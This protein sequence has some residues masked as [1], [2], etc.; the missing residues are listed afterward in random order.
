MTEAAR[1][2]PPT[3]FESPRAMWALIVAYAV[4]VFALRW[5]LFPA[6]SQDDAEQIVFA[7]TLA[8]G[9]NPGQPPLVTWLIHFVERAF[10]APL[11]AVLAVKYAFILA[12]YVFLYL[13]A[14]SVLH[15]RLLAGLAALSP[16]ALLY[17]GWDALVNYSNTIA[18]AV[19]CAA[20]FF[21]F[22]RVV[23]SGS[24][25]AYVGLG[26]AAA[27]GVLAKYGYG[28]FI[29]ALLLAAMFEPAMRKR[30][31]NV[32]VLIA[33]AVCLLI[34]AP[35]IIWLI[36]GGD[37]ISRAFAE[38]LSAEKA[39]GYLSGAARGLVKLAN[40]VVTFL[41]P[42]VLIMPALF[43]PALLPRKRQ[44]DV[45]PAPAA[46]R[47]DRF[48]LLMFAAMIAI[49]AAGV[50]LLGVSNV[51]THY[52]FILLL[53]PLFVFLRIEAV[54]VAAWRL[55]VY[56][57]V[58][59]GAC[60]VSTG[61]LV[62]RH[63]WEPLWER[64]PY[65]HM[66]YAALAQQLRAAGFSYG[67]IVADYD[68]KDESRIYRIYIDG[69]LRAQFPSSR[70]VSVKYPWYQPPP[71]AIPNDGKAFPC[72]LIWDTRNGAA[73]SARLAE[74]AAR[75]CTL[76]A[77]LAGQVRYVE[78]PLLNAPKQTMKLGYVIVSAPH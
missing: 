24:V 52:M 22:A 75:H 6:A 64:K 61:G 19:A 51:R 55:R 63:L 1:K 58:L 57:W 69:N 3:L 74:F 49:L 54:G 12:I 77:S 38:R 5:T 43:W 32:R 47:W 26:V 68:V 67:T 76:P 65:L 72:I 16:V 45:A 18:L 70:V 9:Y 42:L 46:P 62:V 13:A 39:P 36:E 56:G 2:F 17:V 60:L 35:H 4:V 66:P 20:S 23:R 53:A 44:P 10:G 41:F 7:Q 31:L 27:F 28:V 30:M 40:A 14:R 73:L 71:L 59:I 29:G 25:W 33:V 15:D 48:L 50:L 8:A 34:L 78:A 11:F 37:M 21:A